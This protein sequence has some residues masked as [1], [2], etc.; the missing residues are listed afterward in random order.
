MGSCCGTQEQGIAANQQA[1]NENPIRDAAYEQEKH[2]MK[3]QFISTLMN[4]FPNTEVLKSH[5]FQKALF[6]VTFGSVNAIDGITV[7]DLVDKTAKEAHAREFLKE[8]K[9][10]MIFLVRNCY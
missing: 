10:T 1:K 3:A 4:M 8:W 2:V 5:T 7:K 9:G 6:D